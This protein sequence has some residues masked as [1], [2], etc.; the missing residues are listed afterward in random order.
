MVLINKIS[1]LGFKNKY[2]V[3]RVLTFRKEYLYF[4]I[5]YIN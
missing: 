2:S 1:F 3:D 4:G 5:K